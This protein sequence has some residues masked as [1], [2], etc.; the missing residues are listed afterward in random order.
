MTVVLL[1]GIA[2][3]ALLDALNPATIAGVAL[4]LLAP[5]THPI[6]AAAGFVAG[7]YLTVLA[8][9]AVV[10]LG[11]DAAAD[12]AGNGLIWVRR[13]AFTVA[14]VALAVGGLRRLR[15]RIRPAVTVPGR[16]NPAGAAVLGL[17]MTGA[18]LPNAFPYFI[19][20]ERIVDADVGLTGSLLIIAGYALVYCLPCLLLL[21]AGALRGDRV[22]SRLGSLYERLGAEKKLPRSV[23]IA[24]G[25]LVAAVGVLAI[26]ALA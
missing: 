13:I 9:G 10:Y 18:D 25:Y 23:P 3:L 8:L 20:I 5:M 26:V 21:I 14:A 15:D 2:G 19:A 4:L 11:A 22:R 7:A 1:A 24:A 16:V 17:V 6:R 12:A